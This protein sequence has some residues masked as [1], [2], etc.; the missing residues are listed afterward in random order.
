MCG[1]AQK[2]LSFVHE[3]HRERSKYVKIVEQM[4]E[5]MEETYKT[6]I[7]LSSLY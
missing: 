6:K 7:E 1:E 3:C 4:V 2:D 5:V